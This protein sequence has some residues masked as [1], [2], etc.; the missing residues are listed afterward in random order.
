MF[1]TF[2]FLF[3]PEKP[4]ARAAATQASLPMTREDKVLK[5]LS[6]KEPKPNS[7]RSSFSPTS[8][9]SSLSSRSDEQ[10]A[11]ADSSLGCEGDAGRSGHNGLVAGRPGDSNKTL[12]CRVNE[13]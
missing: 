10:T 4:A 13:R 6:K 11:A 5:S 1:L 7:R 3:F 12:S 2:S 9:S 8:R